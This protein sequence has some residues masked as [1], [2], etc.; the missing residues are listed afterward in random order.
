METK[1]HRPTPFQF[2]LAQT[3]YGITEKKKAELDALV[4]N[5][6]D[7]Q[8]EVNQFQAIVISLTTKVSNFQGYLAVADSTR[9]ETLNNKNLVKQLVQSALE[10]QGD[11]KIAF[12]EMETAS[13]KT[14]L[15]SNGIKQLIGQLIYTAEMLNKL[16]AVV[17]RKKALNP[18]ISDEL[19]SL[20][21]TAGADANSAVALTL[22]ALKS[23]FVAEASNIESVGA[24][25]LACTQA[26]SLYET[27]TMP[28]LQGAEKSLKVLYDEAYT[29]AKANYKRLEEALAIATSQLNEATSDLNSAQV[30]LKSLQAGLAAANA[31]ALA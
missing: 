18:L 26:Q 19:V 11:S 29:E 12:G 21:A 16:S 2:P 8:Y 23:T 28:L 7:A 15:L 13:S 24:I 27:M 3:R 14:G 10:L 31:A 4:I 1:T 5:V 20:I 22:V 9:T 6:T 17:T 30:K 25:G